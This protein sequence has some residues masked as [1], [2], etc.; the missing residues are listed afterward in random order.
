MKIGLNY[1]IFKKQ[2]KD[3]NI[4]DVTEKNY[5]DS[6]TLEMDDFLAIN[7][8]Q[9]LSYFLIKI[10]SINSII[11][12]D[13][14]DSIFIQNWNDSLDDIKKILF[15]FFSATFKDNKFLLKGLITGSLN[16]LLTSNFLCINNIKFYTV[17]SK[18]SNYFGFTK[19]E[20]IKL[21]SHFNLDSN[22]VELEKIES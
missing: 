8:I 21:I 7:S 10:Y 19:E 18:Y 4:L 22:I 3:S 14:Y 17:G 13:G 9:T 20:V 1:M 5:I 12:L 6:I 16:I 15:D 11:L 2:L